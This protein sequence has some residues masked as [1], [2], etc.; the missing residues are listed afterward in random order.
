[1]TIKELKQN[2]KDF[3]D[4]MEVCLVQA[5]GT[6]FVDS[7]T[8][9]SNGYINDEHNDIIYDDEDGGEDY[10]RAFLIMFDD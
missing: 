7:W 10:T 6:G 4:D 3:P 1:M 5:S 9:T 2:I 8:T